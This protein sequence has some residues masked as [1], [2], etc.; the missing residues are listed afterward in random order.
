M[1]DIGTKSPPQ[2]AKWYCQLVFDVSS[3]FVFMVRFPR[4]HLHCNA[5]MHV[6][7]QAGK[8]AGGGVCVHRGRHTW[9]KVDFDSRNIPKS[10]LFSLSRS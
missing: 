4:L 10:D 8:Q 9:Q 7:R 5:C 3:Q 6:C 2:A 1:T